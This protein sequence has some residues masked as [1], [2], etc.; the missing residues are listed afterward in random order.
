MLSLSADL[1][2]TDVDLS[3]T[4]GAST[5]SENGI[6]HARVLIEFAEA[7]AS[8]DE[9]ALF[10]ARA[11]LLQEAGPQVLVDVAAVAANFQRMVRI[12]DATGIPQDERTAALSGNI[13]KDLNLRQFQSAQNT[14]APSLRTRVLGLIARPMALF[15]LKRA[16]RKRA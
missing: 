5:A 13:S 4:V 11:A 15:M 9:A 2:E 1:T 3:L 16:E 6:A 14:P 12:A 7:L 10:K 8:G